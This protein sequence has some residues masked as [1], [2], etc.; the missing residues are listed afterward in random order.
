MQLKAKVC[1]SDTPLAPSSERRE[2][3]LGG[4]PLPPTSDFAIICDWCY[5][6]AFLG[7][8]FCGTVDLCFYVWCVGL[9]VC[10]R[11]YAFAC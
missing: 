1:R 7:L 3:G 10:A 11:A 9:Q 8:W 6:F 2:R 5:A 4:P